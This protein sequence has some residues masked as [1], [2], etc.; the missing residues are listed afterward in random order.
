MHKLVKF[1]KPFILP[2]LVAIGLLYAQAMTDLALPDYMSNI[3]NTGIQ[4]GGIEHSVPDILK[5]K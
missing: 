3:V 5:A 4:Q 1:L 2:L